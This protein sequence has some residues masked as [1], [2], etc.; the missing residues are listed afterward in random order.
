MKLL[1]L[2]A[3]LLGLSGCSLLGV[4]DVEG[5]CRLSL[6]GP[7]VSDNPSAPMYF[8]SNSGARLGTAIQMPNGTLNVYSNSGMRLGTGIRG[9]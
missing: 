6:P 8:Y 5:C 9:R 3:L 4:Y 1:A 7:P 2:G